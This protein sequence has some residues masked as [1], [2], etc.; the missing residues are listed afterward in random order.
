MA[1]VVLSDIL[2]SLRQPLAD[3]CLLCNLPYS[4]HRCFQASQG[5][6]MHAD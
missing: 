6:P 5:F 2:S 3:S 1:C 4:R